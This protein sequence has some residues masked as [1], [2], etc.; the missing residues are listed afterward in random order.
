MKTIGEIQSEL[1]KLCQ[2]L[3]ALK[4]E[5]EAKVNEVDL[6][7]ISAVAS[8][9]P[10]ENHPMLNEDEHHK[11]MYLQILFS[12][13]VL[14]KQNNEDGIKTICRIAYG[15]GYTGDFESLLIKA[16][17]MNFDILDEC[18]RLFGKSELKYIL[19]LECMLVTAEFDGGKRR[20]LEYI[21]ELAVLLNITKE[22]IIFLANLARVILTQDLSEYKIDTP[23]NYSVFDCYLKN[24]ESEFDI[25]VIK[26]QYRI[27]EEQTRVITYTFVLVD[28]FYMDKNGNCK[29]IY[30]QTYNGGRKREIN[31]DMSGKRLDFHLKKNLLEGMY[32]GDEFIFGITSKHPLAH[33]M[34]IEKYKQE[35]NKWI[36]YQSS[37][38]EG[39]IHDIMRIIMKYV[40]CGGII[41]ELKVEWQDMLKDMC[42]DIPDP[43]LMDNI[44]KMLNEFWGNIK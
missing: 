5:Q 30:E 19:L 15:M 36:H 10:I 27:E 8:R 32:R 44:M 11:D 22:D 4:Q 33:K 6:K 24:F 39:N 43:E 12:V 29:F 21:S 7:K 13:A 3:E 37:I 2:E 40:E 18:T 1:R 17:T 9:Y 25:Q 42:K 14:E 38:S 16:Q 41:E 34:A 28:N 23:N 31:V 20:A 26:V 35:M